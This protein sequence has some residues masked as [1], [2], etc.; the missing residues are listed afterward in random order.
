MDLKPIKTETRT[1]TVYL[2]DDDI[3]RVIKKDDCVESLEDAK[4]CVEAIRD[5]TLG[6]KAPVLIVFNDLL[7]QD[8]DA[9][10][11][12]AGWYSNHVENACAIVPGSHINLE[13]AKSYL[14][15]ENVSIPTKIFETEEL[16]VEWLKG[17]L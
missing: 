17:F 5:Y 2:G 16:A 3:V 11:Y 13:V 15:Y 14:L 7:S 10:D 12:Y 6:I 4:E 8:M 9:Q 1:A